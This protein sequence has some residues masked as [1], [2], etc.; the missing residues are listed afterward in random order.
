M[1][2]GEGQSIVGHVLQV[3]AMHLYNAAKVRYRYIYDSICICKIKFRRFKYCTKSMYMN[4]IHISILLQA[5]D[6]S[7][8]IN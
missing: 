6:S 1:G 4:S 7:N 2:L 3:M 8:I 5:S